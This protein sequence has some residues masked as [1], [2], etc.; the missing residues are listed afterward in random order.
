VEKNHQDPVQVDAAELERLV[1]NLVEALNQHT[2]YLETHKTIM[3]NL[4][5]AVNRLNNTITKQQKLATTPPSDQVSQAINTFVEYYIN[6]QFY[7]TSN[8][9]KLPKASN[10][11]PSNIK[12]I[13]QSNK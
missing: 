2:Q 5:Q 4:A 1:N 13:K 6:P 9:L 12:R 7:Q 11:N 8:Q 3:E 10:P